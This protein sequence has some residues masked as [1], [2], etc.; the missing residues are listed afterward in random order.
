MYI[1]MVPVIRLPWEASFHIQK[2]HAGATK[3]VRR[4][5]TPRGVELE[6]RRRRRVVLLAAAAGGTEG[7]GGAKGNPP[8]PIKQ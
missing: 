4:S 7:A 5:S 3:D 1:V 2:T 6:G 8:P